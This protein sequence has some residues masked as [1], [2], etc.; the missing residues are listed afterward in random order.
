MVVHHTNR[1]HKGVYNRW[2][3]KF[4]PFFEKRITKCFS[5]WRKG[6]DFCHRSVFVDYR[7][8]V[9]NAPTEIIKATILFLNGQ[10]GFCICDS[11]TNLKL[12]ANNPLVLKERLDFSFI[13]V[14]N[15]LNIE[16]VKSFS[17]ILAFVKNRRP[18]KSCLHR[19]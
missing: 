4:K 3:H 7:F 11:G 10:N 1:L 18:A 6:G 16:V 8:M 2:P 17:K 5:K 19:L 12:I 15:G 13:I 9:N 14:R